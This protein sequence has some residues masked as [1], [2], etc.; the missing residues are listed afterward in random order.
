VIANYLLLAFE[1]QFRAG[2]HRTA[3]VNES[4]SVRKKLLEMVILHELVHWKTGIWH[5]ARTYASKLKKRR[6]ERD[7]YGHVVNKRWLCPGPGRLDLDLPGD[8]GLL[9]DV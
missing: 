6:F 7:L 2:G 9:G 4:Y 1:E 3:L 8:S 5:G